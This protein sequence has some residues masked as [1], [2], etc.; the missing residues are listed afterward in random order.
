M[1]VTVLSFVC[2]VCPVKLVNMYF[3]VKLRFFF[4]SQERNFGNVLYQ[5]ELRRHGLGTQISQAVLNGISFHA[6]RPAQPI[7]LGAFEP[8]HDMMIFNILGKN[9][10]F[11]FGEWV[12]CIR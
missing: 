8:F 10:S 3:M 1:P 12:Q 7:S 4:F 2:Q 5:S 6:T 11:L 9:S